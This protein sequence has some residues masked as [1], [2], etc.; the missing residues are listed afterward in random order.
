MESEQIK[1]VEEGKVWILKMHCCN[2]AFAWFSGVKLPKHCPE[3]G[4][5][6][7]QP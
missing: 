5:K 3:C 1:N 6:V 4:T 7:E 2:I